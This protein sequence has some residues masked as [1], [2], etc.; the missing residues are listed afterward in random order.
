MKYAK[1]YL[2]TLLVILI[3][4]AVKL[5]VHFN[6]EMGLPGQIPVFGDWFK[7]HYT[8][9]PGMAFGVELGSEYGKI[10]LTV[11]RM[12]AAVA[13]GYLIYYLVQHRYPKGLIWCVGLILG[14]AIGNLIDSIFY[15][16]FLDNAPYDAPTPWLHG[17]VIDMFYIDIWEGILPH[18]IPIIGGTP[19]SLWPIFNIADAAIFVGVAIII[20]NQNKFLNHQ[21]Q[22][23][24]L[25]NS[26]PQEINIVEA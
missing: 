22:K 19:M 15:G 16:V 5:L 13:I 12:G 8:L 23:Q 17:Q 11:F 1:Y 10:I 6:M 18:W 9:N 3:D 7:L 25:E 4:H 24:N 2:V 21:P 20:L 26:N 14:G